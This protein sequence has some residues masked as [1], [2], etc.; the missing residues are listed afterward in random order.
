M[1][2]EGGVDAK[3]EALVMPF[4][5]PDH[6][7]T[8]FSPASQVSLRT[9]VS[10]GICA[11]NEENNIANL[12]QSI[13]AQNLKNV[14]ITEIVVVSSACSDNT[15]EIVRELQAKDPRIVLMQQTERRGK[16]SAVNLFLYAARENI[17]ILVSADT[18]VPPESIERICA[19]FS[20]TTVGMTGGHPVPVNVPD[21]FMGF[22]SNLVWRLAHEVSL[23]QPKCGEF[24]AFRKVL[25][26][27]PENASVDEASIEATMKRRGY[28][29]RY[30]P[31]AIVYNR[32]PSTV[33]EYV[34]QRRRI[35]AGHLHL[36]RS[37]GYR[38][39][40]MNPFRL[41]RLVVASVK[42]G[43]R[44]MFW[45]FGA[46]MLEIYSRLLASYDLYIRKQNHCVWD[47]VPSTKRL[48]GEPVAE[49]RLDPEP[50]VNICLAETGKMLGL[51]DKRG[52]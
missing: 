52:N 15:D 38:V 35:Y 20:D 21:H 10:I 45:T 33:A 5:R 51:D 8:E 30:V 14:R 24:V 47:I 25:E 26:G 39:A 43:W 31:D 28:A 34:R 18:M 6:N 2:G 40:S 44:S 19:P 37:T 23:A 7:N 12:I 32:G 16:A 49:S 29:I 13:Q 1:I 36:R 17:C 46:V 11:Y 4:C 42:P 48:I 27:I 41:L 3:S 22:V 9:K 50:V